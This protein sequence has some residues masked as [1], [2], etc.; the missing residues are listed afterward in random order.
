M[1]WL[2]FFA[3]FVTMQQTFSKAEKLTHKKHIDLLFAKNNIENKAK[4]CYPFRVIFSF[5]DDCISPFP[6]VLITVSKRY[7]KK[8]VDR[9]LLKRRTREAYRLNKNAILNKNVSK[10]AFVYIGKGKEDF[11]VIQKGLLKA[12][13]YISDE[14]P[15]D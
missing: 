14:S 9:N 2:F 13:Q 12:L 11:L 15:S 5:G 4:T 3:Y 7:F 6:K 10:L 1:R 8:A